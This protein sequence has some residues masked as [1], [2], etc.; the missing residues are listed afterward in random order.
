[1]NRPHVRLLFR[2]LV[3]AAA[4][5]VLIAGLV[6]C[7]S[8]EAATAC[9]TAPAGG[10]P[11]PGLP[12]TLNV[13]VANNIAMAVPLTRLDD[14]GIAETTVSTAST[15][16][17]LR[18][19]FIAGR[20]DLAA[21]PVNVA[22]NLCAQGIDLVLVGTVSGNNVQLMGPEGTTLDDLRG[23]V[24]HIPFPGDILDLTMQQI[25]DS[26]GLTYDG[27][28]PDVTIEY[29][30]TPL[31]IATGLT[32]GSMTYA[33]LPEHLATVV[34]DTSDS[35]GK[36]V[37]LEQLWTERTDATA[38]PFAG[39]VLRG[40]LARTHP[41]LVAALQ[42]NLVSSVVSVVSSPARGAAEVAARIPVP[43]DVVG[44]VL[45]GLRPVYLPA[46][47]GR[48][49]TELLYSSLL[50]TVPASVGGELPADGFYAGSA[51]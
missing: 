2:P 42:A 51:G 50:E 19:N 18:T 48:A 37:G 44:R 12:D 46:A 14:L 11:V 3:T 10:D 45:P 35:V 34:A 8:D 17:E 7:G 1:V 13:G 28:N 41:D 25:L 22:A 5:G 6:S 47:E 43:A 38:L 33:V 30:P 36:A 23:Q 40:E 20:Y 26:A 27:E 16:E 9:G 49:D 29:H 21:M 4:A 31:D 24:V 39:F 32:S 15:P